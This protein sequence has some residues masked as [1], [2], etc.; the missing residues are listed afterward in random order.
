LDACNGSIGTGLIAWRVADA[1][2]EGHSYDEV[3]EIAEQAIINTKIFIT[4]DTLDFAVKGGRVTPIT[5][6]IANLLR[7][8]P[9]LALGK[10]GI[11]SVG[12]T[13]GRSN[14]YDKFLKY[15]MKNLPEKKPFRSG[16]RSCEK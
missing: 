5:Q 9:I 13:F 16:Y 11:V 14:K 1:I 10:D 12:K 15:L 3:V 4:L 2:N 8:N 7:I 6:T